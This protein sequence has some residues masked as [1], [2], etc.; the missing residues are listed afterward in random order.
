M[1]RRFD[2]RVLAKRIN[3]R[4][5]EFA[6]THPR[7]SIPITDTLSRILEYDDAYVPPRKRTRTAIRRPLQSPGVAVLME[8]AD[9][10][11]TTVGDL[12]GE[13]RTTITAHDRR[14]LRAAVRILTRVFD[15]NN[16]SVDDQARSPER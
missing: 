6:A 9:D 1:T 4:R 14:V 2:I 5:Q 13:P 10:L 8:I 15:L 7:K 12:L 11:G 3:Q 16:P